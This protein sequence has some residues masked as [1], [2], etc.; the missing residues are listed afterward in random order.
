MEEGKTTS[1]GGSRG[2][3]GGDHESGTAGTGGMLGRV[4]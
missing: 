2:C 1:G 4:S 3:W